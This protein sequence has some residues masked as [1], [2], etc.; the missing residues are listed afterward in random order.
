MM[1]PEKGRGAEPIPEDELEWR[2]VIAQ[3]W[4]ILVKGRLAVAAVKTGPEVKDTPVTDQEDPAGA[5]NQ[6][7]RRTW[8][9]PTRLSLIH[10]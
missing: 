10:I 4:S 9:G 3:R 7:V 5:D 1:R 6:E 2:I 8:N